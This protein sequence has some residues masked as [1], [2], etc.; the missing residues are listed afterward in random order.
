M[1][2]KNIKLNFSESYFMFY[3]WLDTDDIKEYKNIPLY[4]VSNNTLNDFIN[5]EFRLLDES[6][7]KRNIVLFSD[8]YDYIAI[9]FD[10]N[11]YCILKSSILL[12]DEIKLGNSIDDLK[13]TKVIYTK[14]NINNASDD[15]RINKKIKET[16]NNE[17]S[18]LEENNDID[19]AQYLYYEWF[20]KKDNNFDKMINH[21]KEK[22]NNPIT[23]NEIYIYD[24]IKKSYKLV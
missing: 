14:N 7:F 17:I 12:E 5:Y 3:D 6:I 16:L 4:R 19:K 11:G 24:L 23:E 20:K 9:M 10:S 22:I 8:T 1:L 2:V 13:I 18:K 21:M 15:L